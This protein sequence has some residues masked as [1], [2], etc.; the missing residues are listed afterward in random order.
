[1][2]FDPVSYCTFSIFQGGDGGSV[3]IRENVTKIEQK[4]AERKGKLQDLNNF[5][6]PY[7]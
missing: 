4:M 1:M 5:I 2:S 7:S 3:F 6:F